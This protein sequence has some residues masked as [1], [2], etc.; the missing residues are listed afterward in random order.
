MFY[1]HAG[2]DRDMHISDLLLTLCSMSLSGYFGYVIGEGMFPLNWVLCAVGAAAAASPSASATA[3]T[4]A[5]PR[6][7]TRIGYRY[8][9]ARRRAP[10][11]GTNCFRKN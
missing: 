6:N 10:S 8:N 2:P 3:L 1:K 9:C 7:T 4:T 5:A 11:V